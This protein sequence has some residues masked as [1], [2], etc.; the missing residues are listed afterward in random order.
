MTAVQVTYHQF[1]SAQL[2]GPHNHTITYELDI[3]STFYGW[4]SLIKSLTFKQ[5]CPYKHV[6][7]N[8]NKSSYG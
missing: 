2:Y 5:K 7:L 1:M 3:S 4:M 8:N 6:K